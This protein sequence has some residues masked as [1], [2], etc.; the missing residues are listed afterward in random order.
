MTPATL[1]RTENYSGSGQRD[2][3]KIIAFEMEELG[4]TDIPEYILTHYN[5]PDNIKKDLK[6]TLKS[7]DNG[8][9]PFVSDRKSFKKLIHDTLDTIAE[10]IGFQ[11]RLGLWLANKDAV[12]T[13]Y[14]GT[15]EDIQEYPTSPCILSD[16][17]E[18][19]I[20]FGYERINTDKFRRIS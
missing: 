5:L 16:L 3:E 14:G 2:L 12:Q 1:F 4:N 17:G 15:E 6:L 7:K 11:P 13:L 10:Q 19:G 18:D 9:Y 20:L 8:E